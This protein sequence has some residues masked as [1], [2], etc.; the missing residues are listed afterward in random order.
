MGIVNVKLN[1]YLCIKKQRRKIMK[2]LFKTIVDE[3]VNT[4][5]EFDCKEKAL[6]YAKN[7]SEE[8]KKIGWVKGLKLKVEQ[9]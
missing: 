9:A 3:V 5:H 8:M 1:Y 4:C 6:R 2:W 7:Y